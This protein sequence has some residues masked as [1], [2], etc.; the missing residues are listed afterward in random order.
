MSKIKVL[1]MFGEPITYGGQESVVYNMLS[2]L[3]LK[4]DFD[5]DLFTPYYADNKDLIEL[6]NKNGGTVY[7]NDIEF[8]TGDNRFKLYPTIK[9]FF[10]THHKKYDVAHIHT[11]SLATMLVFAK[12]ARMQNIRKIII[13]A[14]NDGHRK[15][16]IYRIYRFVLSYLLKK[17]ATD[18]VGCS[19]AAIDWRWSRIISK[20]AIVIKNGIEID[21]YK[22][23]I[24]YKNELLEKYNLKNKFVL[25]NIARFTKEKNQIFMIYL[26]K[27]LA[28]YD[29][30]IFL[31][32]VGDGELKELINENVLENNLNNNV[33]IV[34]KTSNVAEYYSLFD[35]YLLPSHY[36]GFGITSIE[37]QVSALPC[38][39]SDN[40][41]EE[42]KISDKTYFLDINNIKIWV[43]KILEIKKDIE[44]NKE[45][46][47][48]MSIDFKKFD[49]RY[50]FN[51]IINIYKR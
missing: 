38:I 1:E 2:V 6:V 13:H 27:E 19:Q 29:K 34:D 21:K 11:G 35:I 39:I 8:K 33:C 7:H 47:N 14:H 26:I 30:N 10:K 51:D 40:V 24:N 37:A 44:N 18:F 28:S 22:F 49:R 17:Y 41:T 43:D 45:Y 25:G 20:K 23:N 48:N 12:C 4:N 9:A 15:S 36:E 32:L 3:D 5:V 31:F 16:L 46:K 42:C 50:T